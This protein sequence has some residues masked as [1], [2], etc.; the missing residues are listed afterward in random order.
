M[1]EGEHYSKPIRGTASTS[2]SHDLREHV[3]FLYRESFNANPRR[4]EGRNWATKLA[5]PAYITA[6]AAIEAFIN[7]SLLSRFSQGATCKSPIWLLDD[8]DFDKLE[9]FDSAFKVIFLTKAASGKSLD[10]NGPIFRDKKLLFKLRNALVHYQFK[11]EET[12]IRKTIN[13]L[14]NRK[15]AFPES[16]IPP[17]AWVDRVSTT[18]GIRWAYNV[19]VEFSFAQI[20]VMPDDHVKGLMMTGVRRIDQDEWEKWGRKEAST[21]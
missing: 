8:E 11:P 21:K 6:A 5:L 17:V 1:T 18:E 3:K 2:I 7:E 10:K 4:K 15:I 16:K 13:E 9:K 20:A 12:Q 19:I 14:S